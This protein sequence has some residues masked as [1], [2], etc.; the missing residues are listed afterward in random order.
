MG[1]FGETYL[2]LGNSLHTNSPAL[3][4]HTGAIPHV[5]QYYSR[6]AISG[7]YLHKTVIPAGCVCK[8]ATKAMQYTFSDYLVV[9][10]YEGPD[11]TAKD[12][13]RL[14]GQSKRIFELMSDKL[15][16]T[17]AEIETATGDPQTS[18]SAQLRHFRKA[19]F[20]ENT[21]NKRRR[22]TQWEYQ[23]IQRVN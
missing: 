22:G 20:G 4:H 17:L 16:Q 18:C 23:L 6:F 21:V 10:R 1:L 13:E 8:P 14:A 3:D 15:W 12:C 7:D 5:Q 9:A 2:Y 19:R 11:L